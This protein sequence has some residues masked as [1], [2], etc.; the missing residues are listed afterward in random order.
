ML[1]YYFFTLLIS[2]LIPILISV[3]FY[4]LA[5][6]KIMASI[7][8][9]LGPSY[10]DNFGILQPFA[11]GLKAITKEIIIPKKA[12]KSLFII[13]PLIIFGFSFFAWIVIPFSYTNSQIFSNITTNILFIF[14]ISSLNVYGIIIAGWASNSRY[15]FLGAI[16]SAAQMISYE[17]S[18]SFIILPIL[19]LTKSLNVFDIILY[20]KKTIW[21]IFPF[22]PLAIIFFIS[23]L[24]E[25][26]RTPF[27]LPEAEAEIVAG[28]NIEYSGLLFALFFLGE[29]SNMI[30]MSTLNV[31]L[32]WGGWL[33]IPLLPEYLN[34]MIKILCFCILFILIRAILPRYRFDQLIELG[35][36]FFLP[37]SFS[38]SFLFICFLIIKNV[39]NYTCIF[40]SF[41]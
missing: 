12:N 19:V 29:Y 9:R 27:D 25:T 30:L 28:Y 26:N 5:E 35:W 31:I 41:F 17:I 24:A 15:A 20:Q 33:G 21:F 11:D 1:I 18:L 10:I 38:F 22:L 7:Q 13:A 3:I 37:F 2:I 16:R 36:K 34:F 6:R 40:N 32:F 39:F 8:R 23:S 4:T 14:A